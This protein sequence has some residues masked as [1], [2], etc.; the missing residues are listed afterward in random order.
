MG[1]GAGSAAGAGGIV[2]GLLEAALSFC[3]PP[4]QSAGGCPGFDAAV[5]LHGDRRGVSVS[6]SQ[7]GQRA[8]IYAPARGTLADSISIWGCTTRPSVLRHGMEGFRH[9]NSGAMSPDNKLGWI[10]T[11]AY[12]YFVKLGNQR[13]GRP[14]AAQAG[15]LRHGEL[16]KVEL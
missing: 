2:P 3:P 14:L 12:F 1:W 10:G 6:P 8:L 13:A 9:F 15:S 7:N 11:E 4:G 5:R 16:N